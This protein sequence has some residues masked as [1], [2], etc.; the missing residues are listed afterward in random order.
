MNRFRFLIQAAM[1]IVTAALLA[2]CGG[3]GNP[4]VAETPPALTAFSV[5]RTSVEWQDAARDER[6]GAQ[7]V[8][9]KRRLQAYIWYPADVVAGAAP[10]PLLNAQQIALLSS[11]QSIPSE[12]MSK[13]PG[14]SHLEAPVAQREAAY[15]VL[16][17]SHGG[18]GSSPLQQASTAEA[19][20]A[21]GYVVVGLS[22]PYQS[23]ATFYAS[24]DVALLDPA[25]DPL[26]AQPEIGP[27]ASYG[28][29]TAN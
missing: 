9:A 11:L 4:P 5:G 8:G 20:A 29:H 6:C 2:A 1:S 17:M 25:C 19:L 14:G 18:G 26:G 13:L 23:L 27:N 21:R 12:L 16:L 15:P 3:S 28:D 22:H 10:A 7:P 24:G